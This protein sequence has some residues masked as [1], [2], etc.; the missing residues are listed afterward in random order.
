MLLGLALAVG[1][2][3]GWVGRRRGGIERA[4]IPRRAIWLLG[5]AA[6]L[7]VMVRLLPSDA[8]PTLG[9]GLVAASATAA[10][11]ALVLV[12]VGEPRLRLA[13]TVALT[14]AGLN[15]LV[16]LANGGMP[17]SSR[18]AAEV[19]IELTAHGD[20]SASRQVVADDPSARHVV[21]DDDTRFGFL[22]DVVP[23]DLGPVQ[24]VA[25]VGDFVLLTGVALA[26]MALTRTRVV[27]VSRPDARS[28]LAAITR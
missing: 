4:T 14:G 2:A 13:A 23:V 7:Q 10:A 3:G 24:A 26:T 15:A 16:M 6:V 8:R 11:T 28:A 27:T 18:A 22:G 19:G 9:P 1:V 12:G 17:V 20:D 5:G 21:L 25:S